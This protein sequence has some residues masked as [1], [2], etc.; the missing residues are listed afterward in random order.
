[1]TEKALAEVPLSFFEYRVS[2]KEPI[3][4]AWERRHEIVRATYAAF[5]QWNIGLENVTGKQDPANAGEI[6]MTFGLLSG[7]MIFSVGLGYA[8]LFVTKPNWEEADLITRVARAGMES[9]R[10]SSK[11]QVERQQVTLA[12]HL[13]PE[14]LPVRDITAQFVRL[15][16]PAVRK[17]QIRAFGFSF[18][19]D[20]GS[21]VVDSSMQ[22]P[23]AMFVRVNRTFA[24]E[25]PFEEIASALRKEEDDLLDLLQLRLE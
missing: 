9:L 25:M 4:E 23:N 5:R 19:H 13:K 1:M 2:F 14:G 24:P 12:M 22:Y 21:W 8:S 17:N 3:F 18:Y 10:E 6:Q 11:A 15:D 16:Y 7:R 20:E